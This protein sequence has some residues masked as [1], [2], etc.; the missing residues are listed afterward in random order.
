MAAEDGGVSIETGESGS[1]YV[2]AVGAVFT[3]SVGVGRFLRFS[4]C[5]ALLIEDSSS[6]AGYTGIG[7]PEIGC[8]G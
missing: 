2:A 7:M 4:S 6:S 3:C 5:L 1:G 8:G